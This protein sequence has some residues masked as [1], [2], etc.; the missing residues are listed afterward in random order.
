MFD[1]PGQVAYFQIPMT[2]LDSKEHRA[3][4]LK[5]ARESRTVEIP[6]RAQ[7]LACWD[8]SAQR[9]VVE[10]GRVHLQVGASSADVRLEKTIAVTGK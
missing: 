4:V 8:S 6:V 1:P 3:L 7:N 2:E 5:V 9:C 10:P